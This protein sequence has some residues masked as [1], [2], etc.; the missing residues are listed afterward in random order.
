[1]ARRKLR[2]V[3]N[4]LII[5]NYLW[6]V[7]GGAI[8]RQIEEAIIPSGFDYRMQFKKNDIGQ[9]IP[10]QPVCIVFDNLDAITLI[11]LIGFDLD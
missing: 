4:V 1:M 8:I 5:P 6:T 11:K 3:D 7:S 9:V 2:C 10:G